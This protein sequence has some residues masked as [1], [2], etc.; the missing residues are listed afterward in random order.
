MVKQDYIDYCVAAMEI[1]KASLA[2]LINVRLS[3]LL[4]ENPL[5]TSRLK[6]LATVVALARNA[7]VYGINILNLL[8]EPIGTGS[9]QKTIMYHIVDDP[10]SDIIA[11]VNAALLNFNNKNN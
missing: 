3:T 2:S 4:V 9:C 8:N 7:G 5:V 10:A 11:V 6:S 1:S